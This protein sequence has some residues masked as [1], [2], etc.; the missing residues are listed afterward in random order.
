MTE[1]LFTYGTL[2]PGMA[3]RAIAP[4]VDKL[5]PV[6]PGSV[7]GML[8]NLGRYPGA[9]LD[10]ECEKLIFGTVYEIPEDAAIL[11]RLDEYEGFDPDLLES[12]LFIRVQESVSLEDGRDL[13]CWIY[14]Y[15]GKPDSSRLIVDGRFQK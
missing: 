15:S 13:I 14:V 7:R 3:P 1:Y 11:R 10:A 9:I 6:G 12:S 2:Q 4:T 5:T 8:Y